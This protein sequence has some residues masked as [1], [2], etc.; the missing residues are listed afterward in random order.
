VPIAHLTRLGRKLS[1]TLD[2]AQRRRCEFPKIDKPF[3]EGRGR[4]ARW[5]RVEAQDPLP[6]RN[7]E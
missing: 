3:K 6:A 7:S 1:V 5:I 4:A 2:R